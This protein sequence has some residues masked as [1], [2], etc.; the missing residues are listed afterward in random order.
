MEGKP[1]PESD[2]SCSFNSC[3]RRGLQLLTIEGSLHC[4]RRRSTDYAAVF[5][6]K[7]ADVALSSREISDDTPESEEGS[8]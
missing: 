7:N 2:F 1:P 8:W 4:Q 5:V 3:N 6:L